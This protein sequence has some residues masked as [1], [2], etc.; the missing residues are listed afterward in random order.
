MGKE[1]HARRQ[2][3]AHHLHCRRHLP[4]L[5]RTPTPFPQCVGPDNWIHSLD[6]VVAGG[7]EVVDAKLTSCVGAPRCGAQSEERTATTE[8]KNYSFPKACA[9]G[10]CHMYVRIRSRS[11]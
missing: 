3:C 7:E 10:F 6:A 1:L 9:S 5:R 8:R 2:H 4:L 11:F